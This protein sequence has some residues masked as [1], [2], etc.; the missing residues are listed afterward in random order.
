MSWSGVDGQE[1][2]VLDKGIL[3][4]QGYSIGDI[5]IIQIWSKLNNLV[6]RD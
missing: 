4:Q 5:V 3:K 1:V 2:Q 6:I